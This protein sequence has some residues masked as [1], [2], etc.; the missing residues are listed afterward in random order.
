MELCQDVLKR[1]LKISMVGAG[2]IWEGSTFHK[3]GPTMEKA[4]SPLV[5]IFGEAIHKFP[6]P[7]RALRSGCARVPVTK[8]FN[9]EDMATHKAYK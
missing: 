5:Y 2:L 8:I 7:H 3:V 4:R 6:T 9:I 1:D